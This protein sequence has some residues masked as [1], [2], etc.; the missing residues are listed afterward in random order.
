MPYLVDIEW[1]R[2]GR[3]KLGWDAILCE[4]G[5]LCDLG[6][7]G[8]GEEASLLNPSG[9]SWFCS[10]THLYDVEIKVNQWP[11]VYS[12]DYNIGFMGL[13]RLHPFDSG[14]W[15]KVFEYLKGMRDLWRQN[16]KTAVVSSV[17]FH[18]FTC[19]SLECSIPW[20]YLQ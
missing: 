11:V 14:K 17:L 13:E 7:G 15:G 1:D 10:S 9:V 16:R 4:S 6:W 18:G 3:E 2:K 20:F 12:A 19:S 5:G 8:R